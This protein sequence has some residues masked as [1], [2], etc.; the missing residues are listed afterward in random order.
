M[1]ADQEWPGGPCE[2]AA[3][4][5]L[6][7]PPT[8]PPV[9]LAWVAQG[10]GRA[11][12]SRHRGHPGAQASAGPP[13]AVCLAQFPGAKSDRAICLE[14]TPAP[15][16][17][18]SLA[19]ASVIGDTAEPSS[20]VPAPRDAGRGGADRGSAESC[21]CSRGK[22][23]ATPDGPRVT[24][25]SLQ[26]RALPREDACFMIACFEIQPVPVKPQAP[27]DPRPQDGGQGNHPCAA[28]TFFCLSFLNSLHRE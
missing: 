21:A 17:S 12:R 4:G 26:P 8:G 2:V 13:S 7:G 28:L 18:W 6:P 23:G 25:R 11:T 3:V 16:S 5:Q 20:A 19:R 10:R 15:A 27:G 22:A 1:W 9:T 24:F 14:Q